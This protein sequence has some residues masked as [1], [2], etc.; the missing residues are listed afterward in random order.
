MAI[1]G[2]TISRGVAL[3]Q[4]PPDRKAVHFCAVLM[5]TVALM[6]PK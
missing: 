6:L 4:K 5:V 2:L 3:A 1:G